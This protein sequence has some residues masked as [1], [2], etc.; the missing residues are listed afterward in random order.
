MSQVGGT[1]VLTH[2]RT[3]G[4]KWARL[5]LILNSS[6]LMSDS[7]RSIVVGDFLN[8][9]CI[10]LVVGSRCNYLGG[11]WQL[12]NCSPKLA[13]LVTIRRDWDH[14]NSLIMPNLT[15]L[16]A[17]LGIFKLVINA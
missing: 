10:S 13:R 11:F 9:D 8:P 16:K 5:V 6:S 2:D 7:H 14:F 4:A 17:L 3:A 15:T 1:E 12:C